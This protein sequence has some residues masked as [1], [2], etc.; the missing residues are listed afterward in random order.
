MAIGTARIIGIELLENFDVPYF[1]QSVKEFW[2]RWHI[3][4]STWLRDDIYIPL[5][6]SRCSR[7]RKYFNVF[8]T[9]LCSGIWHGNGL[10][11]VVWGIIHGIYQIIGDMTT[12]LREKINI[13]C[14]TK[15]ESFGYHFGRV[16]ITFLLVNF[17]WVFFRADSCRQ[18][19][20][21]FKR[22][23][24]RPNF[25]VLHDKSL[26][27]YGLDQTEWLILFV[28]LLVLLVMDIIKYRKKQNIDSFLMEQP[29]WFQ[30]LFIILLF[31]STIT[32]GVYGPSFNPANFIYF[33][34]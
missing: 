12:P 16:V 6:G 25:W 19:L 34:F 21:I 17:A 27:N 23:F 11:F 5:G 8:V 22:M 7:L 13:R 18:A 24:L 20:G 29:W 30:W 31:F 33:N 26:Y 10:N 3:S 15:V 9:F 2:R 14:K 32:F 28:S 1:S 4:L